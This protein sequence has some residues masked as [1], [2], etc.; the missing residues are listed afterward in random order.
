M[1]NDPLIP[2]LPPRDHKLGLEADQSSQYWSA[3]SP[4]SRLQDAYTT[5][6]PK[7]TAEGGSGIEIVEGPRPETIPALQPESD[8]LRVDSM[9]KTHRNQLPGGHQ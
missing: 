5:E 2:C 8:L 6:N 9:T 7:A 4:A 1:C 3:A